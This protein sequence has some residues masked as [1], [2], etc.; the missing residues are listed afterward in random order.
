MDDTEFPKELIEE[1][2]ERKARKDFRVF[3]SAASEYGGQ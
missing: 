2:G 3:V 1:T